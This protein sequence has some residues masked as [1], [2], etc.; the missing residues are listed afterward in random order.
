M[1]ARPRNPLPPPLVAQGKLRGFDL[2][3]RRVIVYGAETTLGRAIVAALREAGAAVGVTSATTDGNA[4]FALKKAAAGGASEAV[5]LTNAT[6]V[7]VA[8]KKLRKE[9]G[10]L[11]AAV[12]VPAAYHAAPITK[13]SDA[14]LERVL[15][16]NLSACYY[17]FRSAGRE[18]RRNDAGGRLIAV[19]DAPA[20]R[21]LANL[22]AY[23]AAQAGVVGL[24][25]ALSQ[26]LG[27]IGVTTNAVVTGWLAGAPGRGPDDSDANALQ[28]SIPLRRFGRPQEVAP[29]VVY[30]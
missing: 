28:R 2:S 20:L 15:A 9:L 27:A 6:N 4:L 14:D 13:T 8:T 24:V 5:D 23:S 21:G 26:E 3:G 10:G 16:A 19:L 1:N 25:R 18:L 29:L 11:D 17:V 12:V 30:L 22:S 7:Q